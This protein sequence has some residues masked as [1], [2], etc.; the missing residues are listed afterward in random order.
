MGPIFPIEGNRLRVIA[1]P[2]D[3]IKSIQLDS[4]Q[5]ASTTEE[6]HSVVG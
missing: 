4:L 1:I 2:I 6:I 3:E 5:P